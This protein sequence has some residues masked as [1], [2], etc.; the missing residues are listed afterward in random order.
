MWVVT[1]SI[2]PLIWYYIHLQLKQETKETIFGIGRLFYSLVLGI[3]LYFLLFWPL[4]LEWWGYL[5]GIP[6]SFL[7]GNALFNLITL[8]YIKSERIKKEKGYNVALK[9]ELGLILLSIIL[10]ILV[11]II[12]K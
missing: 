11:V 8:Y 5:L 3:L 4:Y 6:A 9:N 1:I 7:L 10:L 2:I 12:N